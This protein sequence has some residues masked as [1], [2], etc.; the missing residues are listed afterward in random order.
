MSKRNFGGK[1]TVLSGPGRQPRFHTTPGVFS[2][3]RKQPSNKTLNKKIKTIQRRQELK[4]LDR[5][6]AGQTISTTE[7][8]FLLNGMVIGTNDKTRDGNDIACTSI[9]WRLRFQTDA[10]RVASGTVIRMIIFWDQQANG[11]N[12]TAAELLDQSVITSEL[13]APYNHDNQKRF[14]ILHDQIIILEPM[15]INTFTAASG[16]TTAFVPRVTYKRGK[17]SLNRITKYD[18]E[19]AAITDIVSNSL[20]VM[21]VSDLAADVPI[22]SG[23]FR[24]YFKDD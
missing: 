1:V 3:K 5:V 19:T 15:S 21:F 2:P 9:Q 17:R 24:L 8:F 18:G 13:D 23:G 20:H 22:V 10:D 12:P 7:G 6:F 4:H 16:V 11:G 14:K